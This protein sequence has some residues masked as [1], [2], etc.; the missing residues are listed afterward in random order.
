[1]NCRLSAFGIGIMSQWISTINGKSKNLVSLPKS[2]LIN[3]KHF[4]F[5]T[6]KR[7]EE[8]FDKEYSLQNSVSWFLL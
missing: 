5:L 4:G 6:L 8:L 1:M 2:S 7:F 3:D